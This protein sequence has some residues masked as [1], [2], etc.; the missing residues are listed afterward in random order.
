M[1][2]LIALGPSVLDECLLPQMDQYLTATKEKVTALFFRSTLNVRFLEIDFSSGPCTK[3]II[4]AL[5]P[6]AGKTHIFT[7]Y[8]LNVKKIFFAFRLIF[9]IRQNFTNHK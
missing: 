1:S 3:K 9:R 7:S 4:S 5:K 2:A 8:D 6:N